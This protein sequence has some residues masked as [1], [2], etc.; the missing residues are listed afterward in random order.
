MRGDKV[1]IRRAFQRPARIFVRVSPKGFLLGRE[2]KAAA[3]LQGRISEITL[4]R[5]LFRLGALFCHSLDGVRARDG[6]LCSACS[7]PE[8]RPSLRV[9]LSSASLLFVIDLPGRSAANFLALEEK[10][11]TEGVELV[12]WIL[13]FSVI[14]RGGWGEVRFERMQELGGSVA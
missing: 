12:D 4:V 10:A 6:T 1:S 8:C 11:E 7:H 9:H 3:E 13:R 14:D 2:R 5:K